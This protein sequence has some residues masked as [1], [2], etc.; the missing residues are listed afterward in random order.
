MKDLFT[1][2]VILTSRFIIVGFLTFVYVAPLFSL[3][4]LIIF[5][6]KKLSSEIINKFF[7]ITY[8]IGFI[9][10]YIYLVYVDEKKEKTIKKGF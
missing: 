2:M 10:N 7:S 6:D 4:Y 8:L 1:K 3:F 5:Q 9:I